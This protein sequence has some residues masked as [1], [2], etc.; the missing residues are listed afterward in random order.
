MRWN[1]RDWVLGLSA[2]VAVL[3]VVLPNAPTSLSG[4]R[5]GMPRAEVEA[6]LGGPGEALPPTSWYCIALNATEEQRDR[7]R[8]ELHTES[9]KY[10]H[11]MHAIE[12]EYRGYRFQTL[13]NATFISEC[14]LQGVAYLLTVPLLFVVTAE[15]SRFLRRR[16]S[17]PAA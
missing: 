10:A 4:L 12:V 5:P 11:P 6:H 14:R 3:V 2:A 16:S 7:A 13:K 9:R 1:A 8:E 17:A 15:L